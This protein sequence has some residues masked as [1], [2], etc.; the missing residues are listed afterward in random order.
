MRVALHLTQFRWRS[1][2]LC[3]PVLVP[4]YLLKLPYTYTDKIILVLLSFSTEAVCVILSRC[5][6]WWVLAACISTVLKV[7]EWVVQELHDGVRAWISGT[8]V[9]L[10]STPQ[11][12]ISV[13]GSA[14]PRFVLLVLGLCLVVRTKTDPQSDDEEF[15]EVRDELRKI[16]AGGVDPEQQKT[17]D[18][19]H[20]S[21]WNTVE[22]MA[23]IFLG[24]VR[25]F[26]TVFWCNLELFSGI[27]L[28]VC[29]QLIRE[30]FDTCW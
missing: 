9:Q 13:I 17:Q 22:G 29:R 23:A 18:V 30:V 27:Q 26:K 5:T 20:A 6:C 14:M 4:N 16:F 10:H 21:S 1:K 8:S 3:T 15:R 2:V 11:R 25:C 24:G 19:F 28:G 12:W 7:H